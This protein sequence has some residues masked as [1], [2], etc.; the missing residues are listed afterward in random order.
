[1]KMFEDSSKDSFVHVYIFGIEHHY[2]TIVVAKALLKRDAFKQ[3]CNTRKSSVLPFGGKKAA[4]ARCEAEAEAMTK[5]G[6]LQ[7][8]KYLANQIN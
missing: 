5:D 2:T 3:G 7:T 6:L 4:I 8:S 1:M